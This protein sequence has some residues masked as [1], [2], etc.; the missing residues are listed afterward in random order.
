M[1][2]IS[3]ISGLIRLMRYAGVRGG[4]WWQDS[5]F[6]LDPCAAWKICLGNFQAWWLTLKQIRKISFVFF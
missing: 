5:G 2:E 6:D 4:W 3:R 1:P